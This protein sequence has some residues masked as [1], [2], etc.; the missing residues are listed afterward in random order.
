LKQQKLFSVTI[1]SADFKKSSN[2]SDSHVGF[3]QQFQKSVWNSEKEDNTLNSWNFMAYPL[4]NY[5]ILL[6]HLH[7]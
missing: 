6:N 5:K 2:K 4:E 3:T 1:H 7:F